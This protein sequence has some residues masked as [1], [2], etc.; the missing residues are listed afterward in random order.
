LSVFDKNGLMAN[1]DGEPYDSSDLEELLD[2]AGGWAKSWDDLLWYID[3]EAVYD[4]DF[5]KNEIE[6]MY[7]AIEKVKNE[8]KPFTTDYRL[9]YTYIT[10]KPCQNCKPS[11]GVRDWGFSDRE[12]VEKWL[13]GLNFPTKKNQA[14]ETAKRNNAPDNII[15][16]LEKIE[17]K[18]YRA[19]GMILEEIGDLT[20]DHD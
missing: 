15:D 6:P 3:T 19:V 4:A 8:G 7:R 16:Y 12:V 10:N 1:I 20:W 17:D 2:N 14:V 5:A 13:K 18:E 9:L 11:K